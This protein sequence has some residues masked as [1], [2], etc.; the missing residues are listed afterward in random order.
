MILFYGNLG[1]YHNVWASNSLSGAGVHSGRTS[2]IFIVTGGYRTRH[3]SI[4]WIPIHYKTIEDGT[5]KHILFFY[6]H[7]FL[8]EKRQDRN[9]CKRKPMEERKNTKASAQLGMI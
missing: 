9:G 6:I 2:H 3:Q 8:Q 5:T 4:C 1:W 7:V